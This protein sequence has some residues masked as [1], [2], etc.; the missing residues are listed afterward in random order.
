MLL[1]TW[2]IPAL[3]PPIPLP[4]TNITATASNVLATNIP[5]TTAPTSAVPAMPLPVP[6][7]ENAI[8]ITT[9]SP[10]QIEI[11]ET[12]EAIYTFTSHGGGLKRVELKHYLEMVGCDRTSGTNLFATLNDRARVPILA[13]QA[14]GE[15][16]DNV[17]KLSRSG[18]GTLVAEKTLSS[19]LRVVKKFDLGSNYQVFVSLLVENTGA[20]S[21]NLPAHQVSIGTATPMGPRD[22]MVPQ[23]MGIFW[24]DGAKPQHT[25]LAWFQPSGGC[26][27]I[28]SRPP[29]PLYSSGQQNVFWAAVHNQFFTIAAVPATNSVASQFNAYRIE[30]PRP[31]TQE[32]AADSKITREPVGLESTLSYPA[33]ALAAAQT[34]ERQFTIYAG[35]KQEKLL[36]SVG[37][38]TGEI[39]DF[40]FF[41]LISKGMLRAMNA[42]HG[43]IAPMVPDKLGKYAMAL[44]VMTIII[45]LLFWPLTQKSTRSM[46]RMAALA[47]EMK[48][49]QEKYKDDPMKMNKKTM[50]FWKEHKV[51]P[52]SGCW[53]ML[54][55]LPIFFALFRM[56][57]NAIEL[58]GAPFLWACDL[59]KQDTILMLPFVNFP[60]NPLPLL[61][62]LTMLVQARMTPPSP[63]M[64][65]AQQAMMRY[66]PLIFMVFL[67]TQPAGLTL[68]W[69][70]QNLLTILQTKLTTTKEEP[71]PAPVKQVAPPKKK[72]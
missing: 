59:S 61:M 23:T 40:G 10:E 67:Y 58:R 27:G 56:I 30:L 65:P 37:R 6:V 50:E 47:P 44:I 60:L 39:M 48:K 49:I 1:Q 33:I 13:M 53:P 63:G 7:P 69:T 16:G 22:D 19:G 15:L 29:R 43:V 62:G 72:K 24:F 18:A 46:K 45:K 57:P 2:V 25:D 34:L 8:A 26:M 64:D 42:I 4:K 20:Q 36:A 52:L 68:Y 38:R 11:L 12:S 3:F 51:S 14:G 54:I 41:S 55:Q 28:G 71:K 66:M 31:T 9:N 35:P 17:F 32:I 5:V 21:I 70:V